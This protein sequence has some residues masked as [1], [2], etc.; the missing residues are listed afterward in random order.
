MLTNGVEPVYIELSYSSPINDLEMI[1]AI[2]GELYITDE[3]QIETPLIESEPGTYIAMD[4]SFRGHIGSSYQLHIN[5]PNG[6][7]Y[8]SEVCRLATPSLLIL[9]M[10]LK[11]GIRPKIP[12]K[13]YLEFSTIS[14]IILLTLTIHV[15]IYGD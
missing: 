4:S 7:K 8:L 2:D 14:T 12:I 15:I 10:A 9:F 1:P 5:M 3:N 13:R 6:K 11:K